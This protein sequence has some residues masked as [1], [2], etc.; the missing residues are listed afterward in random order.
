MATSN[1]EIVFGFK[2][3]TTKKITVGPFASNSPALASLKTNIIFFNSS[4]TADTWEYTINGSLGGDN[5]ADP[6]NEVT[7]PLIV[8]KDGYGLLD[9]KPIIEA[10]ITTT[11]ITE[12]NLNV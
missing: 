2:D 3:N 12:I 11:N 5:P 10:Y 7:I 4:Y 6:L 9:T 8:N 1:I